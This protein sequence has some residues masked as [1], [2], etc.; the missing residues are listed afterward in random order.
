MSKRIL[1]IS[2]FFSPELTGIGKYNGE[3]IQW[4]SEQGYDC[5]VITTYPFYPQWKLKE[6]YTNHLWYKKE[7]VKRRDAF[8]SLGSI[9]VYR[10]PHYIAK[11]PT[12]KARIFQDFTFFISAF[13]QVFV[14][15]F[16]QK[17]HFVIQV[18]PPLITGLLAI[19]YKKIRGSK[20]ICHI[21]DLQADAANNLKMVR[22]KK[23][24]QI[25]FA[26]EK[27]I[28]K[29]ADNI[30]SISFG[31]ICKIKSKIN[32][33]IILFPNWSD[34]TFF[35][36]LPN[37]AFLKEEFG[38]KKENSIV[39]YSGAIG[40][41]QG[42]ESI[43]HTAKTL[44][45]ISDLR[46]I[47]CANGPYHKKLEEESKK[48]QLKNVV[49]LPLQPLEKFNRFLN[50]T[51][52]HLVI[53]KNNAADLVMPSKLTNI[54]AVGGISIVTA[55][56]G[57]TLYEL[58]KQHQMGILVEA[59]HQEALNNAVRNALQIRPEECAK[60]ARLYAEKNLGINHVLKNFLIDSAIDSAGVPIL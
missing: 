46:F 39:L 13:F 33:P 3:M 12:S 42:I 25:L 48:M 59:E 1:L 30:S 9:T 20:F 21:Q 31:M 37:K 8:D 36:P 52:I 53:Q 45:S 32:K 58:L 18:T 17:H 44:E 50:M 28:L 51:D 40:E 35:Y 5:T 54:L 4:F 41:K 57:T 34:T 7:I 23:I 29:R 22:S 27:K 6:P 49:F 47:I 24:I 43:L 16:R 60:N 55:N 26:L 15:L 10:C 2:G 11:N 19:L 38:F 14:L 56:P